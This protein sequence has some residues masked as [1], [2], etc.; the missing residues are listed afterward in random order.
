M[1][2]R[3][4]LQGLLTAGLMPTSAMT[5]LAAIADAGLENS[6]QQLAKLSNSISTQL[7]F[8][9]ALAKKPELLGYASVSKPDLQQKQLTTQGAWPADLTGTLYRNGPARHDIDDYRYEHWFDGDGMLQAYDIGPNRIAH[10]GRMVGTTKYLA[11]QAAGR[12]L[13]PGFGSTPPDAKGTKSADSVNVANISVL[14]HHN[15]LFALWEAGSPYE[16]NATDLS[17]TGTAQFSEET[18]GMP[19]SAHPRVEPDGTLWNFGYVSDLKKLVLWHMSATGKMVKAGLVECDPISMVHDFVVTE[20]HL[21]LLVCPLHYD[22]RDTVNNF[23]D[24]H[25]WHPERAT[26]VLVVNKNDFSKVQRLELPAQWVFHFSNAWEDQQGIIR[27]E[28]ARANDPSV[29]NST[30]RD[31]M[32]GDSTPSTPTHLYSYRIDTRRGTV[33]E[34]LLRGGGSCE[35]PVVSP[36]LIGQP[37]NQLL[38]LSENNSV[39][40]GL[41]QVSLL[42]LNNAKEASYRYPDHLMPEEHLLVGAPNTAGEL[43]YVLG[44][45]LNYV[46]KR[47]EVYLYQSANLSDGP[48]ASAAL[49]YPLP[50][51]LHG[52]FVSA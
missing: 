49:N 52:K 45:A 30:F 12:A 20:K 13:Y 34:E 47:T 32:V 36:H 17:T 9:A 39:H 10:K 25:K 14:H 5:T 37:H 8:A 1:K 50:L 15:T 18:E 38:L 42:T 2:R 48:I 24:T 28:A 29:L 44:T 4:A 43:P 46:A 6:K 40:P 31:I 35:F 26:Q 51:G 27:F 7:R 11:E 33:N 41:N 22:R 21:V 23:L 16:M 3:S 19:F